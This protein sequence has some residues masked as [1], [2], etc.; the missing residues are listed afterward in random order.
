M[1]SERRRRIKLLAYLE[2]VSYSMLA[3]H[4]MYFRMFSD[5]PDRATA[6]ERSLHADMGLVQRLVLSLR[7]RVR[8]TCTR[9]GLESHYIASQADSL[10]GVAGYTSRPVL[11]GTP[12]ADPEVP[13]GRVSM[14]ALCAPRAVKLPGSTLGRLC[15]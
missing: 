2:A 6:A 5:H 9:W 15:Y 1:P 13:E 4:S 3:C 12:D 7:Q 10:V 11:Q 8:A 14:H